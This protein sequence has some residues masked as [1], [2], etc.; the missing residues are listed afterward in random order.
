VARA[1]DG[2]AAALY[3]GDVPSFLE[4]IPMPD[5]DLAVYRVRR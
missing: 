5:T 4:R 3:R 2:L 1:P